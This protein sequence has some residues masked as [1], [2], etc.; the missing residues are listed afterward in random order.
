MYCSLSFISTDASCEPQMPSE[1]QGKL[2]RKCG[3][4]RKGK[5]IRTLTST[6]C[7]SAVGRTVF[8]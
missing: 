1:A 6:L 7:K 3:N 8:E 5:I 4:A 2:K